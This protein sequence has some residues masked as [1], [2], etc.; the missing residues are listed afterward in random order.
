[1]KSPVVTLA[2][3]LALVAALP[4]AARAL[5]D[6]AERCALDGVSIDAQ[7]A[8]RV[9]DGAAPQRFCCITC[10]QGWIS[11]APAASRGVM[12]VAEDTGVEI[13]AKDA[14]FVRSP[15]VAVAATDCRIHAFSSEAAA[16]EHLA[17]FRGTLLSGGDRPFSPNP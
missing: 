5:R 10:A 15:V 14:W 13:P 8:V 2:A 12:V 1:M 11:R 4:F 7:H 6:D 3:G 16:R 17:A 9:I